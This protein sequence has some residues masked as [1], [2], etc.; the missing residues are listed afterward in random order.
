M[1]V[2]L[3]VYVSGTSTYL[4]IQN[5]QEQLPSMEIG[6]LT[7]FP[8]SHFPEGKVRSPAQYCTWLNVCWSRPGYYRKKTC[9]V[10]IVWHVAKD[11]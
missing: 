9:I 4:R 3:S 2:S 6:D 8:S 5:V 1:C 7:K 10:R 11:E